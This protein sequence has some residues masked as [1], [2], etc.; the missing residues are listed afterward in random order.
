MEKGT[1]NPT[2][3]WCPMAQLALAGYGPVCSANRF[4]VGVGMSDEWMRV[5]CLGEN[6]AVFVGKHDT[7]HCGLIR[8]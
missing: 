7:G 2:D 6:C 5:R 1:I 8:G 4:P 3:K